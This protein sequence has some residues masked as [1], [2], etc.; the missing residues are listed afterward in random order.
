MASGGDEKV[1]EYKDEP[2]KYDDLHAASAEFDDSEAG[3]GKGWSDSE[4]NGYQRFCVCLFF[5][6]MIN[7]EHYRP[8]CIT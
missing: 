6:P 7:P 4:S 2:D 1:P 8:C 3:L 5:E